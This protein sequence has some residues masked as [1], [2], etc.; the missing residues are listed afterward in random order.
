VGTGS[1][2]IEKKTV[3]TEQKGDNVFSMITKI[4]NRLKQTSIEYAYSRG[5][6]LWVYAPAADCTPAEIAGGRINMDRDAYNKWNPVLLKAGYPSPY[7]EDRSFTD[8][9]LLFLIPNRKR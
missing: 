3:D 7:K 8:K 9:I 6:R 2:P 1:G 4:I 5:M